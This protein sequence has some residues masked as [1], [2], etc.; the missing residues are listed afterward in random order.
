MSY[1]HISQLEARK[2]RAERDKLKDLLRELLRGASDE[3]AGTSIGTQTGVHDVTMARLR[4]AKRLGYAV[5]VVPGDNESHIDF[6]A[7]KVAP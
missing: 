2:L 6:R 3:F 4:T 5:F 1:K 7:L